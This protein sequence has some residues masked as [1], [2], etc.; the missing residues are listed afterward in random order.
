VAATFG[1]IIPVLR[2]FDLP[3]TL[4]FYCDYLG[5]QVDWQEGDGDGPTYLQVSRGNLVLHLSSHHGDG[6]PGTAVFIETRDVE[7]LH[8]ELHATDYPFFNPGLESRGPGR[9]M[10]LMDPASNLLRFFDR[11][12]PP[13]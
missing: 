12:S 10:T 3:A 11:D 7:S 8:R 1:L 13:Q 2:M 4:R 5:C 9:E 6:T